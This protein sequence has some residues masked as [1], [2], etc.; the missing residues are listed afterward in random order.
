MPAHSWISYWT[1]WRFPLLV[2]LL[3]I[4][5]SRISAAEKQ[6][7]SGHVPAVVAHQA[8]APIGRF[9]GT[10]RLHLA[11]SLP[12]RDPAGL[13]NF[14][15]SI[16]RPGSPDFH[17]YLTSRQFA[18]RFGP[19]PADYA[20]MLMFARTNGLTVTATY[21]NRLVVDVTGRASDIER[22]F[23]L[24]LYLYRHPHESRNFFA[25]NSEPSVDSRLPLL[26]V[27]G[28]DNYSL[29]HP[30]DLPRRALHRN[31][32]TPHSGSSPLGTYMGNDFRQAYVP[33]TDLDGTGQNVALLQFDAFNSSDITA[34]ETAIG[35]TNYAPQVVVVPVDGG[36]GSPGAGGSEVTL[37]IDMV[38]AMAPGVS[39]I[40]VY[41]A[42]NPSPWVDLLS[43]M[44]S[45]NSAA[46]LSCSW[47][48][49]PPDPA[50]EQ[51]FLQMAAQGQTF[52]NATGDGDAYTNV[53]P[54]PCFSPNVTQVGG[55]VLNTDTNGNYLSESAWN[56]YDGLG[57][58]GGICPEIPLPYWQLGIDLTNVQGSP[59]WRNDPDVS[60]TADN[61]YLIYQSF[62]WTESGTSCA[63]PLWAG[64]MALANQEAAQFI[65]PPVGFL[66]ATIYGLCRG[67]NY[68]SCFHDITN[69]DNTSA[70]SPTNY[71]AMPGYDLCTG[72]GTPIGNNL[73]DQL[74]IRDSLG[75]LPQNLFRTTAPSGGWLVQTNCSFTL[76]NSGLSPVQWSLGR[77]TGW[78]WTS[79]SGGT[80]NPS[81]STNIS[82]HLV[83]PT[84]WPDGTNYGCV[85][86]TNLA[87]S[88][89]QNVA[90]EI[91]VGGPIVQNGDFE[92]GDFTGW[93]L[94]GQTN[95]EN[96]LYNGV[97]QNILHQEVCHSGY[98]GV[99]FG[100]SF[101]A[102]TL[103]QT[104]ATHPGQIYLVSFWLNNNRESD[105]GQTF[106]ASWDGT[107]D[108]DLVNP[109]IFDWTNLLF[110]ATASRTNTV[111][112]FAAENDLDYFGFDDVGVTPVPPVTFASFSASTNGFQMSWPSLAGLSYLLQYKTN[113]DEPDW[114]ALGPIAAADVFTTFIDTNFPTDT[115]QAFY[116]LVMLPP[117]AVGF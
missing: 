27:S 83:G 79:A 99:F 77:P 75:I 31:L 46:Q 62:E 89:V 66:N 71:F 57:S 63:A 58:S 81:A 87:L 50:S 105:P 44:A 67:N 72:W 117:P 96:N 11:L 49:G 25:P 110:L 54:F 102:A 113:I 56:A 53:V 2:V 55:T 95:D 16:Y 26:H 19:T 4:S 88:L 84:L 42:P 100:Q 14:L 64:L 103:S 69:G 91:V 93:T 101:F 39:N 70:L 111:L 51:V 40:F 115:G 74:M 78:L 109:P 114:Q 32:M 41:E 94:V 80:L 8:I 34:Y 90:V 60:L 23:H 43:Q 33:G 104:L 47:S 36:V 116:R 1:W 82:L 9:A 37:D 15:A 28:L 106:S 92:T 52:F 48:G 30:S 20:A 7:P 29:P 24:K 35:L 86:I 59:I 13:S 61:V 38:M 17:H 12:L 85:S 22:T 68:L 18:D 45:D 21:S 108:V 10:N 3:Y 97:S 5:A 6:L 98:Y 107:N 76:T 73:I 65:Q 112:T